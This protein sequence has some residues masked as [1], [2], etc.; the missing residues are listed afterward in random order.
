MWLF[1]CCFVELNVKLSCD[2]RLY[3][4]VVIFDFCFC[5]CEIGLVY[6]SSCH[7][8]CKYSLQCY[9]LLALLPVAVIY[10]LV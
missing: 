5:F 7:S 1:V 2:Q 9:L 6:L 3:A 10:E 4:S 8:D